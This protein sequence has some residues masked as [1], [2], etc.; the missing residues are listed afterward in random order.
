MQNGAKRNKGDG[1]RIA[2]T[3]A[4]AFLLLVFAS[5]TSNPEPL[6]AG[7]GSASVSRF[8]DIALRSAGPLRMPGDVKVSPRQLLGGDSIGCTS[9][10]RIGDWSLTFTP[11][12]GR[13]AAETASWRTYFPSLMHCD[14]GF[15][16]K[17]TGTNG[18]TFS[19]RGYFI[20]L[21]P[22]PTSG[23]NL[24]AW[25]FV[26]SSGVNY[27]LLASKE[28]MRSESFTVL[29]PD[30]A[31]GDLQDVGPPFHI[32]GARYCTLATP[33]SFVATVRDAASRPPI[34]LLKFTGV[35]E[36]LPG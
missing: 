29:D 9:E 32:L 25:Q 15:T 30:C 1:L 17:Q 22:D 31:N 14:A 5:C 10:M 12:A 19:A 26:S 28:D 21:E 2:W 24:F 20:Q 8:N 18:E 36:D 13:R 11:D 16:G 33:E 3:I 6:A 27:L 35:L 34:G 23:L 4:P 7:S